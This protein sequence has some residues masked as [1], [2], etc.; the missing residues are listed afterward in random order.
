MVR[1][2]ICSFEFTYKNSSSLSC[3]ALITG[4]CSKAK[5]TA[6]GK[7]KPALLAPTSWWHRLKQG[8]VFCTLFWSL[9]GN[10]KP[11]HSL[12][13]SMILNNTKKRDKTLIPSLPLTL[14]GWLLGKL[15]ALQLGLLIALTENGSPFS[16]LHTSPAES[17]SRVCTETPPAPSTCHPWW[18]FRWG[19]GKGREGTKSFNQ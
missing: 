18:Q 4:C 1:N 10:S 3:R 13:L 7:H 17:I 8:S 5:G 15:S 9:E 12:L 11:V 16:F 6:A 19:K 2:G 14:L